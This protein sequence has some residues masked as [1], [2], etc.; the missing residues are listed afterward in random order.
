VAR[1]LARVPAVVWAATV[2]VG[3][4]AAAWSVVLPLAEGPD[5]PS[6]L[7]LVLHLADGGGYPAHDGL[8]RFGGR[9]A[10]LHHLRGRSARLPG[11]G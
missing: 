7:G 3:A 10:P 4:L 2:A 11:A 8:A 1:R 9:G 5:E 6:H